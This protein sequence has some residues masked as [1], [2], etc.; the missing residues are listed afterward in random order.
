MNNPNRIIMVRPANFG[1]NPETA[2]SNKFQNTAPIVNAQ[3]LALEEFDNMVRKLRRHDIEV[4][5]LQDS[6]TPKKP[7]AIFPNNWISF[8]PD[9]QSVLYPMEA[10]NRRIERRMDVLELV[11]DFNRDQLID[12]THF[13]A[14]SKFLEGTGSII[15]DHRNK[16]AFCAISSRSDVTAFEHICQKLGFTPISFEAHD[17]NGHAIYHTNVLLSI[18]ENVTVI[19]EECISNPIERAMVMNKLRESGNLIITIDFKQMAKFAGNCLEVN[20]KSGKPYL[21]MSETA[22]QAFSE[23]TKNLIGKKVELIPVA[24]PTIEKIGGGSARCMMLGV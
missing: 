8:H 1:Y 12:L 18:G 15:F 14:E 22:F 11:P 20:D 2:E 7:D 13:E 23:E 6:D 9:G 10:P 21:I 5:V 16:L 4:L 17:V 19:C 3:D 24:I